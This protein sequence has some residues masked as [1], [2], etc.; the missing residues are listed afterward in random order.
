MYMSGSFLA[1]HKTNDVRMF[2]ARQDM[3]LGVKVV[4]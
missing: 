4:L 1:A 2:E 3:D